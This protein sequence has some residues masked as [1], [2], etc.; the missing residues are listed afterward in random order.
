MSANTRIYRA[1]GL[2]DATSQRA[3]P[4]ALLVRTEA[5]R[6]PAADLLAAGD[7]QE[8]SA[9]PQAR[10]AALTDL[11]DAVL[12][13]GLVNAHAHL[14]LTHIGPRPYDPEAG[15]TG[16]AR[17][18]ISNR[19][20][21]DG[22]L[23]RSVEEGIRRSLAGGVV[24]VGDIAGIM[25]TGPTRALQRS[26]LLGCSFIEYFGLGDRQAETIQ[27][28]ERLLDTTDGLAAHPRIRTGLQPHAPYTAGLDLY[29]WTTRQW[30]ERGLRPCT[31]LAE[32]PPELEFIR[33]ASGDFRDLL[34]SLSLWSETSARDAG[35]GEHPIEHLAPAL[36][37]APWLL[38]HVNDC[39][40]DGLRLLAR[41]GAAV[42]YCPRSSDYFRNNLAFGPHRYREML[43]AG[44]TVALGTDSVVNLPE[45][46]SRRISTLDEMRYLSRRDG[47][48]PGTLLAMATTNGARALGL[49]ERWFTLAGGPLAGL[50]AVP[51]GTSGSGLPPLE[52]VL[53][54]RSAPRLLLHP[55]GF[56]EHQA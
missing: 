38:A 29:H 3:G 49:D 5:G 51:V 36:P 26:P 39:P 50:V 42:A 48:D 35:R 27:A 25:L 32:N 21:D 9:H 45:S 54:E 15:F 34:V 1:A 56:A 41:S 30:A 31:H 53:A 17:L 44:I 55:M 7:W 6:T 37:G 12:L 23:R 20:T 2:A 33:H 11:P 40:D 22:A 4:V 13:P 19:L 24:A 8:V 10:D 18:I 14:D 16:W 47:T 46:E 28:V 43:D 52:R